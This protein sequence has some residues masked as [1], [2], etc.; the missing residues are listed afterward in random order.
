MEASSW[1]LSWKYHSLILSRKSQHNFRIIILQ[2]LNTWWPGNDPV[3]SKNTRELMHT[4]V[5]I[6][7]PSSRRWSITHRTGNILLV[8]PR[9]LLVKNP[10]ANSG[11]AGSIPGSGRSPCRRKWQLTPVFLPGKSHGQRSLVGLRYM[12]SQ[13]VEHDWVTEHAHILLVHLELHKGKGAIQTY[14]EGVEG[15]AERRHFNSPWDLTG[16]DVDGIAVKWWHLRLGD[17]D[18]IAVK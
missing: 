8:F 1:K 16:G 18:G 15:T 10:P 2:E 3:P 4:L 9:W 13:S 12:G 17:M 6:T 7:A 11:N 14:K 5:T